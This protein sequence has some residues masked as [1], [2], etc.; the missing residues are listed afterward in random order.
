MWVYSPLQLRE[1]FHIEF[2]RMLGRRIKPQNYVLK[3]GV[4]LRLFFKSRRYSEDMDI[5]ISGIR[6][7]S[8]KDT[9][10]DIL[11]TRSFIDNLCSF[12]IKKI[13]PP[14]MAKAKQTETTQR[15]KIHIIN[16]AGEDLFTKIE[17]SRRGVT[18]TVLVQAVNETILRAYK[19]SQLL[20]PHYDA[21]SAVFQKIHALFGRSTVQA[22]D[23]FDIFIVLPYLQEDS[24]AYLAGISEK[25]RRAAYERIFEV[26]F[27]VFKDTVVS[28]LCEEDMKVYGNP[29]SWEE[30][31]IKTA[32]CIQGI[33]K[34]D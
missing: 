17:F 7:H 31:R 4:N 34:H 28:Y 20:T 33:G 27:S 12:G 21:A 8:L 32:E 13:I 23:I 25:V 10:T 2:L 16:T 26:E 6:V 18:G 29:A 14:D 9:V 11:H 1:V 15:F 24:R 22:R 19:I 5:D 3:G 30:I